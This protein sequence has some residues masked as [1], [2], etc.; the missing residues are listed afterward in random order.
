MFNT[1]GYSPRHAQAPSALHDG[2]RMRKMETL[3]TWKAA[4][5]CADQS[6]CAHHR[7]SSKPCT[8][9]VRHHHQRRGTSYFYIC[10]NHLW[11]C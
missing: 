6:F 5:G 11:T 9:S 10:A 3:S 4:I 1:G 2:M 8:S 7:L